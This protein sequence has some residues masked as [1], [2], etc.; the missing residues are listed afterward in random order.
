[1][2]SFVTNKTIITETKFEVKQQQ[3]TVEISQEYFYRHHK[4]RH[5]N[6]KRTLAPITVVICMMTPT[7][8]LLLYD[9][10][11]FVIRPL[12]LTGLLISNQIG[13]YSYD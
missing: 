12:I 9:R 13:I 6:L 3:D 1:M 2:T 11:C 7:V 5:E 8:Q 10:Y 4:C